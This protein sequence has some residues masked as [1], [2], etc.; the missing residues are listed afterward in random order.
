MADFENLQLNAALIE[1]L[2]KNSLVLCTPF[3][4]AAKS[5]VPVKA[6]TLEENQTN[7]DL[8]VNASSTTTATPNTA[9][10]FLG[11]NKKQVLIIVSDSTAIHVKDAALELL[12]KVLGACKLTLEDVALVNV[13]QQAVQLP[14][15]Q[16]H[17][18]PQKML[19]F[20]VPAVQLAIPFTIPRYRVQ[21][22]GNIQYLFANHLDSMLTADANATTEKKNLW[23][24]LKQL[25]AVA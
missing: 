23:T 4:E 16:T 9:I 3:N 1:Q 12:I 17:F 14:Q 13:H 11:S 24:S 6:S 19:I 15:L 10:K 5:A 18:Q 21:A 8:T 25:F 2:Y 22:H 20:G 7:Q